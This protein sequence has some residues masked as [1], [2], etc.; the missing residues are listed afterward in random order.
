MVAISLATMILAFVTFISNKRSERI[1]AVALQ[2]DSTDRRQD[3]IIKTLVELNLNSKKQIDTM[4]NSLQLLIALNSKLEQEVG[5]QRSELSLA[6]NAAE[7]NWV[8][9]RE[10]IRHMADDASFSTAIY[11]QGDVQAGRQIKNELDKNINELLGLLQ[12]AYSNRYLKN[13]PHQIKMIGI[14]SRYLNNLLSQMT[15][16]DGLEEA[17]RKKIERGLYSFTEWLDRP[18][19]DSSDK[20]LTQELKNLELFRFSDHP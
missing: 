14:L 1:A 15:Y 13:K 20:Q 19:S 2:L 6:T 11:K 3:S 17:T 8:A 16:E 7:K 18:T 10:K 5:M 12:S 4:H 9:I